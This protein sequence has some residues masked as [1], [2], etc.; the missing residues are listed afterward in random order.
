M[1]RQE[2]EGGLKTSAPASGPDADPFGASERHDA[3]LVYPLYILAV[4]AAG[5]SVVAL[6]CGRVD[7][8]VFTVDCLLAAAWFCLAMSN[9]LAVRRRVKRLDARI[10]K[11]ES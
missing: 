3:L 5:A 11:L 9:I 4:A 6:L 10:A 8:R 2:N 1:A 7:A